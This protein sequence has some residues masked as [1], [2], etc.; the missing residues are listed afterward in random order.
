M[1]NILK[2]RYVKDKEKWIKVT[3]AGHYPTQIRHGL[4]MGNFLL[5]QFS[6]LQTGSGTPYNVLLN[7]QTKFVSR[8]GRL[9]E[10]KVDK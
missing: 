4:R 8:L 6:V 3:K 7:Q 10:L 1:L 2:D 9:S 5:H